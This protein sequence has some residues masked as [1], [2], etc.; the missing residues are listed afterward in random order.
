MRLRGAFQNSPA[1]S[2]IGQKT[3]LQT[4]SSVP[5][6]CPAP[7]SLTGVGIGQRLPRAA[8][9]SCR[10]GGQCLPYRRETRVQLPPPHSPSA[11]FIARPLSLRSRPGPAHLWEAPSQGPPPRDPPVSVELQPVRWFSHMGKLRLEW[12]ASGSVPNCQWQQVGEPGLV[13]PP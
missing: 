11:A 12:A 2:S 9:K 5:G 3:V 4:R 1:R 7:A 13:T 8:A 6:P 10:G